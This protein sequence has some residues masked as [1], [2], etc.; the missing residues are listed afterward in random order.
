MSRHPKRKPPESPKP[1]ARDAPLAPAPSPWTGWR[2]MGAL[3]LLALAVRFLPVNHVFSPEAVTLVGTD[4]Y[5]H[6]RRIQLTAENFPAAPAFDAW[7]NMPGGSRVQWPAGFDVAL[8][9]PAWLLGGGHPSPRLVE[10]VAIFSIPLLAVL[11]LPLTAAFGRRFLSRRATLL[12][13]GVVAL[14][15]GHLIYTVV[16]RVDH[17]VAEPLVTFLA[18]LCWLRSAE[19]SRPARAV[20]WAAAAGAVA[21]SALLVWPSAVL[22][23]IAF[24]VYLGLEAV[25]I[26]RP[27]AGAAAP[28]ARALACLAT[29]TVLAVP[30]AAVS[31]YGTWGE[32]YYFA[33]STFH[34]FLFGCGLAAVLAIHLSQVWARRRGW[35]SPGRWGIAGA[36][37]ALAVT[38]MG[39]AVPSAVTSFLDGSSFVRR[40]GLIGTVAESGGF[41]SASLKVFALNYTP[42]FLLLPLPLW[43][44]LRRWRDGAQKGDPALL[45]AFW[46]LL[47]FGG[48]ALAQRRF[49]VLASLP[50]ALGVA[51]LY[52]EMGPG[53]APRVLQ[54]LSR[55]VVLGILAVL[56]AAPSLWYIAASMTLPVSG[57]AT[58]AAMLWLRDRTPPAGDPGDPSRAPAWSVLAP[59]PMGHEILYVGQRPNVA[60][61]FITPE[62]LPPIRDYYRI[63]FCDDVEEA[64]A[65]ARARKARYLLV[66]SVRSIAAFI[67]LA[68]LDRADFFDDPDQPTAGTARL[69]ASMWVQ[70]LAARPAANGSS[71][72]VGPFRL[73]Y[74]GPARAPDGQQLRPIRIFELLPD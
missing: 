60:N 59:W 30:F 36:A 37:G 52:E 64:A 31:P 55:R 27:R 19:A 51:F 2:G 33:T 32:M 4:P 54:W 38:A 71:P 10:K 45:M 67:D 46:M 22:T 14:W 3:I 39:L 47:V 66:Q 35:Q 70:L 44:M 23:I 12:A 57:A 16:A 5:Y 65:M 56:L 48:L 1:D 62:H 20:A 18:F 41:A 9:A 43:L 21:A 34:V 53:R 42:A 24:C 68:D 73:V 8:A 40:E 28:V 11:L 61:P 15:P 63:L 72:E 7:Q 69:S 26:P 25:A 74:A 50:F 13:A 29:A 6:M 17:H 49:Q 58:R